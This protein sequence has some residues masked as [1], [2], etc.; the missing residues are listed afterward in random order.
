[1]RRL[2]AGSWLKVYQL[3]AYAPAQHQEP[4]LVVR[5]ARVPVRLHRVL[6]G[7]ARSCQ[8]FT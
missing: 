3:P 8:Q 4:H 5:L 2:I 6:P 7:Q 1:M